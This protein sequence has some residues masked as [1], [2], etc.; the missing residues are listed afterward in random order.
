M[1]SPWLRINRDRS[2]TLM[3]ERSEM[4]QGVITG[5]A[6]LAAEEMEIALDRIRVEFTPVA[7][8]RSSR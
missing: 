7:L 3:V 1:L 4:G 2:I 8:A 5:L 6:M